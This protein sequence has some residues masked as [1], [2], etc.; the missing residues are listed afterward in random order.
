LFGVFSD[1][2]RRAAESQRTPTPLGRYH[3]CV[4]A[5]KFCDFWNVVVFV[6]FNQYAQY[7]HERCQGM[8]FIFTNLV[9]QTIQQSDRLLVFFLSLEECI[10]C[11]RQS[12][13]LEFG[14]TQHPYLHRLH[15]RI[16]NEAA[17]LQDFDTDHFTS[18][19]Q[20]NCRPQRRAGT[21]RSIFSQAT[22]PQLRKSPG[23]KP[24]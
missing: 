19:I 22:N 10:T 17:G 1:Q 23:Y 21:A 14:N 16:P 2:R 9:N 6:L 8:G 13:G 11:H 7:F 3:P 15:N 20:L 4:F 24:L 18:V 5:L 12:D